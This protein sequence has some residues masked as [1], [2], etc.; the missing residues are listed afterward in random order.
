MTFFHIHRHISFFRDRRDKVNQS[1]GYENELA[2]T[3]ELLQL[4]ED[5][6]TKSYSVK[7]METMFD[8]WRRKA[9]IYDV[10]GRAKVM[11]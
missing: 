1:V 10:P 6:K 8:H 11:K 4:L 9:A 5:F 7:E 2:I 3:N